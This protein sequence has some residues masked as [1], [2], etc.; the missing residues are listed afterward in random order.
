MEYFLQT[1]DSERQR[2][3]TA[4]HEWVPQSVGDDTRLLHFGVYLLA[5]RVTF[6]PFVY[7]TLL[8]H[9]SSF[10]LLLEEEYDQSS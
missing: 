2:L 3:H 4:C 10:S 1:L 6:E 5:N 7:W 9:F 8:Q